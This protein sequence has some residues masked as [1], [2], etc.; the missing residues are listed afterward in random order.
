MIS[1]FNFLKVLAKIFKILAWG[2]LA[3]FFIVSVVVLFGGTQEGTPKA[4]S[5]IFLLTGGFHFLIFSCI[6][7]TLRLLLD[8][9]VKVDNLTNLLEKRSIS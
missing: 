9:S 2:A 5:G 6:S 8:L 4:L 1:D 7:G 3:F